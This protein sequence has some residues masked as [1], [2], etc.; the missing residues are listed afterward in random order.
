MFSLLGKS[1]KFKPVKTCI[2]DMDGLI[3]GNLFK[4]IP[5]IEPHEKNATSTNRYFTTTH[6]QTIHSLDDATCIGS[7]KFEKNCFSKQ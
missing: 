4:K 5:K 6:A 1:L 3:L 2:F 7:I